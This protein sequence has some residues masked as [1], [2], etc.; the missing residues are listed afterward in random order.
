MRCT[1]ATTSGRSIKRHFGHELIQRGRDQSRSSEAQ[2]DRRR[3]KW[4]M[5]GNFADAANNHGFKR[6]R[7]RR[8]WNQKIQD[9]MIAAVQNVRILLR[10]LE[11]PVRTAISAEIVTISCVISNVLIYIDRICRE[12]CSRIEQSMKI[13]CGST[14]HV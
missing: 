12:T 6:S 10:N 4:L 2:R 9:F 8:L 13:T 14:I 11:R 5:E 7:W 3:R 1:R